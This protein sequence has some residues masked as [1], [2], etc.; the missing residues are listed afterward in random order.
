[1]EHRSTFIP[2]ERL[3]LN[4][5]GTEGKSSNRNTLGVLLSSLR[6]RLMLECD[7]QIVIVRPVRGSIGIFHDDGS[8]A[9]FKRKA[10]SIRPKPIA[11]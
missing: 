7:D 10:Y 6:R 1:M 4:V 8:D 3:E 2:I 9:A 11:A 5:Y